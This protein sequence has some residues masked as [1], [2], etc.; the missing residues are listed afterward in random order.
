MKVFC[1]FLCL[2]LAPHNLE[3][4]V[5]LPHNSS[6]LVRN[7]YG[8]S[9][10]YFIVYCL[11]FSLLVHWWVAHH[12]RPHGW[13]KQRKLLTN[14]ILFVCN[15]NYRM[16]SRMVSI[17]IMVWNNLRLKLHLCISSTMSIPVSTFA[18]YSQH[19]SLCY[20]TWML[21][22]QCFLHVTHSWLIKCDRLLGRPKNLDSDN[23]S[24]RV[25]IWGPVSPVRLVDPNSCQEIKSTETH[26][27]FRPF[28]SSLYCT[29]YIQNHA[30]QTTQQPVV[31]RSG[32]PDVL[33]CSRTFTGGCV[34]WRQKRPSTTTSCPI[35]KKKE[36]PPLLL[37]LPLFKSN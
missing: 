20:K 8:L 35:P 13:Q 28:S 2:P 14:G 6:P 21:L 3:S 25:N 5:T 36:G 10:N 24:I 31:L 29:Y 1:H 27:H 12:R 16:T 34:T 30:P 9:M 15:Q 32:W 37:W 18:F 4:D 19:I 22:G 17:L 23:F 7:L 26:R 33:Y 11:C